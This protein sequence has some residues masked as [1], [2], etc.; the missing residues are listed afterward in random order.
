MA[1]DVTAPQCIVPG[2]LRERGCNPCVLAHADTR[3]G[4]LQVLYD[5]AVR[6]RLLTEARWWSTQR[7]A[8]QSLYPPK[9]ASRLARDLADTAATADLQGSEDSISDTLHSP[10][11][12]LRLITTGP[13]ASFLLHPMSSCSSVCTQR[14]LMHTALP[15]TCSPLSC[16]QRSLM[17][18]ALWLHTSSLP[19]TCSPLSYIQPLSD[20]ISVASSL[21]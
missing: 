1:T 17:H 9:R 18:T 7:S 3:P 19:H 14:F 15:H 10:L 20:F 8:L 16:T 11:G 2:H 5:E 4:V 12:R 21:W 6:G 13:S